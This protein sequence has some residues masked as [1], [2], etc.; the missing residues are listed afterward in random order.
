[1]PGLTILLAISVVFI[2]P[3]LRPYQSSAT[4]S[5]GRQSRQ[6]LA[7]RGEV[8]KVLT[9]SKGTLLI[10]VRPAREFGEVTVLA[11]EN[12]LVGQAA[13]RSDGTDL[14]GLLAGDSREDETITAAELEEGDVV[15]VIY[16]ALQQNRALEIYIH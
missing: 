15:S 12:D 16:D 4:A 6:L 13:N 3:T 9:Q 11:R 10:T 8:I 7:V 5:Q 14:I 1:M 2:T